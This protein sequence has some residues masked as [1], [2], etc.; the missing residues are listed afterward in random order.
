[1]ATLYAIGVGP[2][3]PDLLTLRAANLL[4]SID[5]V[6]TAASPSNDYSLALAIAKPHLPAYAQVVR[7]EFPMTRDEHILATAWQKAAQTT[8]GVLANGKNAAFLTLGDP[9]IYSTFAYLLRALR[10]INPIIEVEIVPGI[11]SFQAAAAAVKMSLCENSEPL[12]IIPGILPEAELVQLLRNPGAA[13]IL[14]VYRNYENINKALQTTRRDE[15][16]ITCS[17]V[18]EDRQKIQ[19]GLPSHKPAYMTL[20]LAEDGTR[21]GKK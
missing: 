18:E 2:G 17:N 12:T 1:M 6:L 9:L 19:H 4:S 3:A 8:L 16:C 7:L 11:T 5:V 10:T 20:I 21:Q 14:K 13:A 15:N